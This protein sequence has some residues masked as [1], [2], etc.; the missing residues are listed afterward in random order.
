MM[1]SK[2]PTTER[3]TDTVETGPGGTAEDTGAD[4]AGAVDEEGATRATEEEASMRSRGLFL[5]SSNL[6]GSLGHNDDD[7]P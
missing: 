6:E 7:V 1:G 5:V 3:G 4:G 2:S